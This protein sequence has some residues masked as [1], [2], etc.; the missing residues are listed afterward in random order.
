MK[1]IS[2]NIRGLNAKRKQGFLKE[3]IKEGSTRH[4]SPTGNKVCRRGSFFH[5]SKMLEAGP[6]GGSGC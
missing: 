1:I 6:T 2:W 5:S 3:R 4:I